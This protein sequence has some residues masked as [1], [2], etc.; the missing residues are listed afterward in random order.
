MTFSRFTALTGLLAAVLWAL[1]NFDFLSSGLLQPDASEVIVIVLGGATCLVYYFLFR[2]ADPSS[3]TINYL[4]TLVFK[5]V[6]FLALMGI[7]AVISSDH[8]T[9]NVIFG[10]LTYVSFTILEI[11]ALYRLKSRTV[12]G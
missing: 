1:V 10:F 11:L 8:L 6:F 9:D 12:K 7:M 2:P 3:F 4:L 5:L